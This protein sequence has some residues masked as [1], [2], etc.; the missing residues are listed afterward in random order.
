MSESA[1]GDRRKY[2]L[3]QK[4][5]PA[6]RVRG[7]PQLRPATQVPQTQ[8]QV[9]QTRRSA[10]A[11]EQQRVPTRYLPGRAT[12]GEAAQSRPATTQPASQSVSEPNVNVVINQ[13]VNQDTPPAPAAAQVS[14][15]V[16]GASV[17]AGLVL[18]RNWYVALLLSIF[19]GLLGIDAFYLGQV[20]KGVLKLLTAGLFGILWIID[21]V[22][23]ATKSVR[24][25]Q[26]TD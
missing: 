18:R 26:W 6:P 5:L 16:V 7:E 11:T 9:P 2:V 25:I 14:A 13:N 23:I 12:P 3:R 21:I 20:A 22:M 19:L 8:G 24:H 15:L 17:E 10:P 4:D 1:E